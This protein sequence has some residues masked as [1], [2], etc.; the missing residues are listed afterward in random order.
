MRATSR[1]TSEILRDKV[2]PKVTRDAV[3]R[4]AEEGE[5]KPMS[6]RPGV[7][8]CLE[9]ARLVTESYKETEGEPVAHRRAKA[10]AKIL[11]NMT[12][13]IEE[14]QRIV[15]NYASRPECVAWYPDVT[16]EWLEL[17]LNDG[18]RDVLDEKGKAELMEIHNYWREKNS[19]K[20]V[21][22]VKA[23]LKH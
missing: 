13:Y 2:I 4:K 5:E 20:R 8:L 22:S 3:W 23:K 9:R 12:I 16:I 15:G 17:S 18:H 6:I 19:L 7:K 11:E 14:G 10:L 1:P 21:Y